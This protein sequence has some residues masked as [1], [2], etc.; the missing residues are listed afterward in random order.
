MGSNFSGVLVF[1]H[2]VPHNS[3]SSFQRFSFILDP[4]PL[5]SSLISPSLHLDPT[6]CC[7]G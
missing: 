5:L 4:P 2:S 1:V 3:T 6:D 7:L